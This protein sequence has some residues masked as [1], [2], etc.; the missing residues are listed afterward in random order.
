[1]NMRNKSCWL[2]LYARG[3]KL[4]PMW[5]LV[6]NL[7]LAPT[8]AKSAEPPQPLPAETLSQIRFD[9]RIN[10]QVPLDL[11]FRDDMGRRVALSQYFDR[12][13]V[14]LVLG[15]YQCPML[16]TLVLNGLVAALEDVKWTA[17]TEFEVV[18]VSINPLETP[19]LA[20]AKKSTYLRSYGRAG[21]AA[22]WHFLT[23]DASSIK[24][25]ADMVGFHYAYDPVSKQYAHPSGVIVLTPK[26]KVSQYVFGVTYP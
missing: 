18:D 26:G 20:A 8:F 6:L 9:Q 24:Q 11:A 23:G 16:C 17:G 7:L 12:K 19:P 2:M 22:G 21:A 15:Y 1:M 13:P 3:F 14:V 10:A 25:L 4:V 5:L